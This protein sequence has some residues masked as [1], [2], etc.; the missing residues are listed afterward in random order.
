MAK[1]SKRAYR[2]YVVNY[3]GHSELWAETA[4]FNTAVQYYRE[5]ERYIGNE[6]Y[7]ECNSTAV[8]EVAAA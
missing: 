3:D 6:G 8:A 7:A 2:V 4:S 1:S 5:A